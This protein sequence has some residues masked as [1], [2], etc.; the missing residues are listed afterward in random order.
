M[1]DVQLEAQAQAVGCDGALPNAFGGGDGVRG[2]ARASVRRLAVE[3]EAEA[4]AALCPATV[5]G[6]VIGGDRSC[7]GSA[8]GGDLEG[9]IRIVLCE[10][11]HGDA[12]DALIETVNGS[13]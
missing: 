8:Y 6:A 5:D 9:E 13:F 2:F 3:H 7:I 4:D 11:V 1:R 10:R 12:V